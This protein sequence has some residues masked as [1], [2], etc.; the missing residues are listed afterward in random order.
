MVCYLRMCRKKLKL[1][2]FLF[3]KLSYWRLISGISRT[4]FTHNI[5]DILSISQPYLAHIFGINKACLRNI[6]N[7]S[8]T[9]SRYLLGISRASFFLKSSL[10][11][12]L[13]ISW[14]FLR[15]LNVYLLMTNSQLIPSLLTYN[16]SLYTLRS[17]QLCRF[18]LV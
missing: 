17:S 15:Y 13:G 9:Y 18:L 6:S 12:T 8:Q 1:S 11:H 3:T 10:S 14:A 16:N 7:I 5:K 4:Y 2:C